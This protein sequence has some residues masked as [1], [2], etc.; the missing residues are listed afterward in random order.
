M[1][2][3]IY[4]DDIREDDTFFKMLHNYTHMEWIPIICRSAEEAIFFL[5]YY[6]EEFYNVIIDLDH[7]LGEG[8]EI[9]D[10]IALSGYDICKYIIENQIPL[11]GFHIHSMNPVGVMNMRQLLTHYG[12]KEIQYEKSLGNLR[13]L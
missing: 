5:N 6:N 13:P 7:D 3:Y 2:I 10:S 4:V 9:D 1:N 11:V 8:N 12:Y